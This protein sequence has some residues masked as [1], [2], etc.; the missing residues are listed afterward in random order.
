MSKDENKALV[1]RFLWAML[2]SDRETMIECLST[3]TCWHPPTFAKN[4]GFDDLNG[5]DETIDFLCV[6]PERFYEPDSRTMVL[7]SIIGEGDF[8]AALFDFKARPLRGGELTSISHFHFRCS[9]D[10]IA[11]TWEVLCT[12]VMQKAVFGIG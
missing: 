11:E 10:R 8:V 6:Q 2:K 5:C 12:A 1:E 3:D 9:N 4:H 7:H